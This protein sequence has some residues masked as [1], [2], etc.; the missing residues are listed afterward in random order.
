MFRGLLA[1]RTRR[2]DRNLCR[3]RAVRETNLSDQAGFRIKDIFMLA[4]NE[5][6]FR[7]NVQLYGL[8]DDN[9]VLNAIDGIRAVFE[10]DAHLVLE[11]N[12]LGG[13]ADAARRIAHEVRLFRAHS[14]RDAYCI[15]K[16]V[17]YSAGVTI[18]AAF[19][20]ACRFLTEDAVLLV[21]ER[22]TEKTLQLNGPMKSCIQIVR[23]ELALLETASKL[24]LDG[25]AE[26][27]DGS[28]ITVDEL[29]ERATGNGYFF[30]D[31]AVE[32]GLVAGILR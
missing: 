30:A 18:L 12:T 29:F 3:G 15:G 24:E 16:T 9:A 14:G 25:F 13:D 23:E 27:I 19:P 5:L 20:K 26:L 32:L 10:S 22:R 17:V 28:R 8:I 11:L 31:E 21:H 1:R 4:P 7:S 2:I 6:L